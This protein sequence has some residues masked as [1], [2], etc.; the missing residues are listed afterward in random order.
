MLDPKMNADLNTVLPKLSSI[1]KLK[2]ILNEFCQSFPFER[3]S[4]FSYSPLTNSGEGILQIDH[5][6]FFPM[7]SI[8]ENIS[9]FPAIFFSISKKRPF[10]LLI[11][12]DYTNFPRKYVEQF[13][14][15][16]LLIVPICHQTTVIGLVLIDSYTGSAPLTDTA[17]HSIF[18]YFQTVFNAPSHT[19]QLFHLSNRERE[20]LQRLADGATIDEM[21]FEMGVSKFTVRDYMSSVTRKL[22]ARHR[23]EAVAIGIREGLIN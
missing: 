17:I 22:G 10:Y 3:A 15:T 8:K 5:G 6:A 7:N 16:S 13:Q 1:D 9:K 2:R 14:L 21:A 23:S 18:A 19:S 20:V 4:V 11:D 12:S